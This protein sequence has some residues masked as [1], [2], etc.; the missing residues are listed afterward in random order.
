MDN[1]NIIVAMDIKRGIGFNGKIPWTLKKD[2]QYFKYLTSNNVVI[3]GRKTWESI[4]KPLTNRINV[5]ISKM[6][7]DTCITINK[8]D[9]NDQNEKNTLN[10]CYHFT[11]LND[12]IEYFKEKTIFLIG[13]FLIYKEGLKYAKNIYVT[14]VMGTFP[15]DTYMVFFENDFKIDH[16]YT[17][18]N[19]DEDSKITYQFLKY[20]KTNEHGELQYINLIHDIL[21][22]GVQSDDRTGT[23]TLSVF[24]R[25]MKFDLQKGFPLL[26]T[27]KMFYNGIFHE[28]FW[29]LK[30]SVDNSELLK[31]NVHIWDGN[32]SRE[33]LDSRGLNY[34]IGEL[35]PIY[36]FQWR[37]SGAEYKGLID[38]TNEGV[39]QIKLLIEGIKTNPNSRRHII[40]AWNV[41]D[42][43]K[44]AIP[45]CH[46]M[47]QFY[48]RNG[49]LDCQLYQRSGDV[50]L[51]VP[52]NIASYAL[53]TH[54]VA[55]CCDLI[56]GTFIHVLGDAHIYL[57]HIEKI[58]I[59][60]KREPYPFPQLTIEGPK[61]IFEIS[62][63]NIKL[64]NYQSHPGIKMD[65]SV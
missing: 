36:G 44:M 53:L 24:G 28:L 42:L 9:K 8:N 13:G 29:F 56:P 19:L 7:I 32:S 58:K 11:S 22:N 30:G 1:V 46:V 61:N 54:I 50:G 60:L 21:S 15:S 3:M 41:K 39:D 20:T 2:Q 12:A 34:Q 6:P 45:P 55:H 49:K 57:N 37:H 31:N 51:G 62:M 4:G 47:C 17:I 14:N 64:S 26:T 10:N 63:N 59:Q 48:V 5:V 43:N 23:G 40:N 38:Y 33:Y 16:N 35:G 27:K 65:L 25:T 52:F 18:S